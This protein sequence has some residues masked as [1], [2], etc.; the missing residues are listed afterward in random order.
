M[1]RVNVIDS[2]GPQRGQQVAIAIAIEDWRAK[3]QVHGTAHH[4]NDRTRDPWLDAI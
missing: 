3:R 1:K 4:R 2:I